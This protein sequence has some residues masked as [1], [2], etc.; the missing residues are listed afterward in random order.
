MEMGDK[1][2]T[3]LKKNSNGLTITDIVNKSKFSRSTVRNALAR[4]EG[5]RKI[6]Y[7]KI[8]MAKIYSLKGA[9]K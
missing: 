4:L 6:S 8:G 2:K 5:A 9:K 1:I 7:K 3:I